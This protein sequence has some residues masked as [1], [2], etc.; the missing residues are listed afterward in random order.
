M[1]MK[2]DKNKMTFPLAVD[3]WDEAEKEA[4]EKVVESNRF[5]MGPYVAEFEEKFANYFGSKYAVMVNSGSSA[6]LLAIGALF[7]KTKNPLKKGDEVIVPAVSWSTTYYPINQYNLKLR[8]VD[9]DRSTLNIDYD[10]IR[11]AITPNTKAIFAVN[12]LG[13]PCNMDELKNIC[14][15]YNLYLIEDNCESMGATFE[16]KYAGTFGT[17]GTFSTFFSHHISTMEGGMILTDDEELYNISRSLRAHGWTRDLPQNSSLY[18]K[19]DEFYEMFNF[20]L[21]GYNLRPL[22]MSGA[23]GIEQLKKINSIVQGRRKNAQLF[24]DI[25]SELEDIDYQHSYN[26]SSWFGFAIILKNQLKGKRDEFAKQLKESGIECRPIVAG[27][28]TRNPVIKHL[29]YS[30]Y[31]HLNNADYIHENGL[32]IGNNHKDLTEELEYFKTTLTSIIKKLGI[33]L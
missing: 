6:N 28:F 20:I 11:E 26:G 3:S 1:N 12:L 31:G 15:E 24:L 2:L 7:H 14:E 10:K 22:E 13:N 4:I 9:I 19:K 16:D 25:I 23:I 5:T 18:E 27:N 8:F 21:P 30:V 17:I 33:K 29:D 32:F